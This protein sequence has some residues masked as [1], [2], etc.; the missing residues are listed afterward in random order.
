MIGDD[1]PDQCIDLALVGD[2]AFVNIGQPR[3]PAAEIEMVQAAGQAQRHGVFQRLS[4][5]VTDRFAATSG[6]I[7]QRDLGKH[8][9]RR[10]RCAVAGAMLGLTAH[11][12]DDIFQIHNVH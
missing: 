8:D 3:L 11:S 5:P 7:H 2:P 9:R 6:A 4:G 10:D 1:F 12:C